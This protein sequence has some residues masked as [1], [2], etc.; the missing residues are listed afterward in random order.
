[1]SDTHA[2]ELHMT[3]RQ[4][5]AGQSLRQESVSQ[6]G[7][8]GFAVLPPENLRCSRFSY[9]KNRIKF[10]ELFSRDIFVGTSFTA[11]FKHYFKTVTVIFRFSEFVTRISKKLPSFFWKLS[12]SIQKNY[13]NL[14]LDQR[15]RKQR[16]I[17]ESEI[18]SEVKS[19]GVSSP[20]VFF[21]DIKM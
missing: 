17:R 9:N 2:C 4:S 1:M 10:I 5:A 18:I 13:R 8:Q 16:T 19:F 7:S 12:T 11:I 3:K 20:L 15:I 6:T 21:V 14:E